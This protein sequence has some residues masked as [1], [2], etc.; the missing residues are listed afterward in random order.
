MNL[1]PNNAE[2]SETGTSRSERPD[3]SGSRE[4]PTANVKTKK[5]GF[6]ATL[7]AS[8]MWLLT[9]L[10]LLVSV[11]LVWWSM[12][13][14]GIQITIRFPE[15]HGLEAE[16]TVRFRGIEVGTV[17]KVTLN[18]ELSGVDVSV[19]LKPFA[20]PLARHGSRFWIVRPELSLSQ[21]SGLDTAVGHK[22]IGV[23]PGDP[24]GEWQVDFDGMANSP[25]DATD[26]EGTEIILRGSRRFG[27]NPGSPLSFRGIIIGRVLSVDLARDS[28]TVETRIRVYA[29]HTKLVTSK[30][31]F[32]ASSGVDFEAGWG[33]GLKVEV[34]SLETI[35]KGGVSML[36]TEQGG[37]PVQPGQLYEVVGSPDEEWFEQA[38]QTLVTE[39]KNLRSALKLQTT[40]QEKGM[41]FGQRDKEASYVGTYLDINDQSWVVVPAEIVQ[42]PKKA[43][44][45]TF[46]LSVV[47]TSRNLLT[48]ADIRTEGLMLKLPVAASILGS[49]VPFT[50]DEIRVP[51]QPEKALAVRIE[52][53][54]NDPTFLHMPIEAGQIADAWTSENW[55][56]KE[57]DG[58]RN[59]WHGAPVISEADNRLIGFLFVEKRSAKVV[60]VWAGLIEP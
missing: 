56:L 22:Y 38:N 12:P 17:E 41:L 57:F 25:P 47:G 54:L 46:K 45:D 55:T 3:A 11:G 6:V 44:A 2:A 53:E 15:G 8:Y 52:G 31:K 24:T 58:D 59:V 27:I 60:P 14:Q 28:K 33:T 10:C 29:E 4:I 35:I 13:E 30:T 7:A 43:V 20:E 23:L 26:G 34:D 36:T 19:N 42:E 5:P 1:E 50:R 37:K 40:W 21:V 18:R 32:W 48:D 49:S 16:D 51:T 9:L 39:S